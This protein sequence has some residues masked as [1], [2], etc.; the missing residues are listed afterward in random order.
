MMTSLLRKIALLS[1]VGFLTSSCGGGGGGDVASGGISGTGISLGEITGFG[2]IIVNGTHYGTAG[3][4]RIVDDVE[5]VGDDKIVF[6]PG[7][8]AAV[9]ATDSGSGAEA[10]LVVVE[11]VLKG[12][13]TAVDVNE[14][15]ITVLGQTVLTP[16]GALDQGLALDPSL[17]GKEVKVHGLVKDN[18]VIASL[19]EEAQVP[20]TVYRVKGFVVL[21]SKTAT[22]ATV[23]GLTVDYAGCAPACIGDMPANPQQWDNLF[24]E[25]KG[26]PSDFTAGPPAT[27]NVTKLE[28]E[29]LP[30]GLDL[31]A[32]EEFEIEGFITE[33]VDA[34]CDAS[35]KPESGEFLL[36]GLRTV[37][38][39]PATVYE[40]ALCEEAIKGAK[41]EVEGIAG[42]PL[43]AEKIEFKDPVKL[44]GTIAAGSRSPGNCPDASTK[45]SFKLVGLPT[46]TVKVDDTLSEISGDG[47]ASVFA[48]LCEGDNVKVRAR[49]TGINTVTATRV[50]KKS[51][52]LDLIL[53]GLVDTGGVDRVNQTVT[54]LGAT[55]GTDA[56]TQFEDADENPI[57]AAAFFDP[58]SGVQEGDLVK[59]KD[60]LLPDGIADEIQFED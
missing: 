3:A 24:V 49:L 55:F 52:A 45:G 12:P 23:G 39:T 18:I 11:D 14:R 6:K 29:G 4:R 15:V 9:L 50:E 13:V 8:V 34:L 20:L 19:V 58:I 17:I 59:I 40:D 1:V 28:P 42:S 26:N 57:G 32:V 33:I 43:I 56:N 30:Q 22:T 10:S 2:S 5:Q 48:D 54:V 44:E 21:G 27:L 41:V 37:L 51:S 25:A 16:E 36:G 47:N 7:M 35:G 53:Q 31:D 46:I 60:K 38:T